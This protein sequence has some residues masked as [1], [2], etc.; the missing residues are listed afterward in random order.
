MLGL[1]GW[2]RDIPRDILASF[3]VGRATSGS[4]EVVYPLTYVQTVHFLL[5]FAKTITR[6]SSLRRRPH[7]VERP[8][9]MAFSAKSLRLLSYGHLVLGILAMAAGIAS[10]NV[11]D[12]YSGLVGMGIWLGAWVSVEFKQFFKR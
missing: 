12:Y 7:C 6:C 2:P 10:M 5:S 11:T 3:H 1:A 9:K 8:K 4:D